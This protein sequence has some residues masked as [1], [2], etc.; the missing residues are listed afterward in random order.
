MRYVASRR[1]QRP[2]SALLVRI[3]IRLD[4]EFAAQGLHRFLRSA[5]RTGAAGG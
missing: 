5:G 4:R 3:G 1:L 2:Q